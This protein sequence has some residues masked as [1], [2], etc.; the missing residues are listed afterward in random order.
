MIPTLNVIFRE[1][2]PL[3]LFQ[4]RNR[5]TY[6]S[7]ST[8]SGFDSD[9]LT[10]FNLVIEKLMIPTVRK[11]NGNVVDVQG[12]NL[13]IEKLMIP[14]MKLCGSDHGQPKFQ[15]RNRETYDSNRTPPIYLPALYVFQSRN[16]E[17]YDSN[18]RML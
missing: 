16:R 10:R 3:L 4:S 5:E 14:T 12:F 8:S 7:N 18:L 1:W 2:L 9:T 13:V 17:T 11:R 6:D 15:S